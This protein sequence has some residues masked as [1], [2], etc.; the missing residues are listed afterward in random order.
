MKSIARFHNH[1]PSFFDNFSFGRELS[2]A[3]TNGTATPSVNVVEHE[4]GFRIDVAAPG[5]PK[6][7]FSLNLDQRT[8]TITAVSEAKKET[9][10]GENYTRREFSYSSFKRSF[11]LPDTVDSDKIQAGYKDGILS[12]DLPKREEAKPKAARQ[13]EII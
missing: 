9:N 6:E 5:L 11:T 10:D 2:S 8:L 1:I 4:N 3:W 12:V 13:I 7:A